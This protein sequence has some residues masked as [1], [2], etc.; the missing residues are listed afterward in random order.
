[1]DA[2]ITYLST[3]SD[4]KTHPYRHPTAE[5]VFEPPNI[6]IYIYKLGPYKWGEINTYNKPGFF[7]PVTVAIIYVRPFIGVSCHPTNITGFWTHL[8]PIKTPKNSPLA[9]VSGV[10]FPVDSERILSVKGPKVYT[11]DK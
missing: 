10:R 6:Y 4:E 1:M 5:K 11:P 7:T 8:V 3:H 2:T 9:K